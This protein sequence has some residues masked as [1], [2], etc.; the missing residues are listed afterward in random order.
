MPVAVDAA[1]WFD[2]LKP[3]D[4]PHLEREH[5]GWC[6]RHYAPAI[7]LGGNWVCATLQLSRDLFRSVR[8][9]LPHGVTVSAGQF[10]AFMWEHPELGP[11]CCILGDDHMRKLWANW[12]PRP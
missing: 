4:P 1:R 5:P 2:T 12:L 3:I 11:S 7:R 10:T 8:L 6:P 9:A